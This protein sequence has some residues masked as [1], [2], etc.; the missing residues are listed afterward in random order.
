MLCCWHQRVLWPVVLVSLDRARSVPPGM[1]GCGVFYLCH[2]T[3]AVLQSLLFTGEGAAQLQAVVVGAEPS[4]PHARYHSPYRVQAW[5]FDFFHLL[6]QPTASNPAPGC[7]QSKPSRRQT[8]LF[9]SFLF[10]QR[11][12]LLCG[13]SHEQRV[14]RAVVRSQAARQW[15][16][17][18]AE[19][20]QTV[21]SEAP[22][23][24]SQLCDTHMDF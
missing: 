2:V 17:A 23:P 11:L 20:F 6:P 7:R 14:P 10:W 21:R 18:R 1:H 16:A 24:G 5:P 13:F 15:V 3:I 12:V 22:G 9:L 19:V 8:F 4:K